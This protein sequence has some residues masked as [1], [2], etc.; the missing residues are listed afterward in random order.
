M[1]LGKFLDL[2]VHQRF[3]FTNA[4]HLSDGFEV[5]LPENVISKKK[6]ELNELG[7]SGQDF[8]RKMP[9]IEDNNR[10]LREFTLVNCWSLGK[11]ESYALWKIYLGGS[12]AGIAIKTTVSALRKAIERGND[13]VPENIFIGKVQYT[14]N[15]PE[16]AIS[17]FS[18][19]TTKKEYY[20]Y[21]NELRLFILL[22]ENLIS[23][24]NLSV[25][26][27][28]MVDLDILIDKIYISP[29]VGSWFRETIRS[30]L[31][32]VNPTLKER[33]QVSSILDEYPCFQQ[34]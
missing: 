6:Q 7:F 13:P 5:T 28:V 22:D 17:P 33:L 24:Y 31:I 26:R 14:N 16:S 2:L 29:F 9:L 15:L 11:T 20:A 27:Y 25:G 30:I 12:K 4:Q 23:K 10:P 21:E 3:F 1:G 19:I 32:K 34:N 18:L 8:D